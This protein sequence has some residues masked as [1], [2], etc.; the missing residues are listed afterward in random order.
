M[1]HKIRYK[2][3]QN[4]RDTFPWKVWDL[5]VSRSQDAEK[6]GQFGLLFLLMPY[7]YTTLLYYGLYG[8]MQDYTT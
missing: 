1:S 3:A 8:T 5:N 7:K 4:F 6:Q 2:K